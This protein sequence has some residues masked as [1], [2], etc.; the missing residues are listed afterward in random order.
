[1]PPAGGDLY[2]KIAQTFKSDL[3]VQTWGCQKGRDKPYCS[4]TYKVVN[5]NTD[6]KKPS[7]DEWSY[8]VDHSKWSVAEN[9]DWVCIADVNRAQSQ[10]RRPGGALC[11]EHKEIKTFFG[12]FAKQTDDCPSHTVKR[13]YMDI[14]SEADSDCESDPNTDCDC[15]CDGDG[16]CGPEIDCDPDPDSDSDSDWGPSPMGK[17]TGV[18]VSKESERKGE[19]FR[20]RDRSRSRG[21]RP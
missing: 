3:R 17:K 5:V 9:N 10:Y 20:D 7:A 21:R 13:M 6:P 12:R 16:D 1:M 4:G 19:R 2:V 8:K 15:D 14:E 18:N 11:I